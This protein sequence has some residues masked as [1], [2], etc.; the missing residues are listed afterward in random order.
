MPPPDYEFPWRKLHL[1]LHIFQGIVIIG[2]A[3]H[4]VLD[5]N[6][7]GQHV[8]GSLASEFGGPAYGR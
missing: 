8:V 5:R 4:G 2:G 1:L 7:D 3:A 6:F